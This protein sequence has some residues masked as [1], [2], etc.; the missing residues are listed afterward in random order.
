[1]RREYDF[2][3]VG[4]GLS[5]A[6]LA[7]RLSNRLERRCLLID[8]RGHLAGNAY[9]RHD[10]AGVLIHPYGPHYFRTNSSRVVE[11]LSQFT[12]W[13]NVEYKILSWANGRY[14]SFPINLNT[15][16]QFVGRYQPSAELLTAFN[17]GGK[18]D[19]GQ[20]RPLAGME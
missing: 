19:S 3:I 15:F 13:H 18:P 9:D 6:V 16:E 14:W 4:A 7:E 17:D 1:M 10:D 2:L 8:R 11:Y 5:G 20:Q 12:D